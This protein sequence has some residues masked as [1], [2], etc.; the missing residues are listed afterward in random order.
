M[1]ETLHDFFYLACV[2][3]YLIFRAPR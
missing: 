1:P 2:V 3:Q